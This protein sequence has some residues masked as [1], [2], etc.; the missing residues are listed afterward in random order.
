[1]NYIWK[2]IKKDPQYQLEEIIDWAAH[3]KYFQ[4]IVK[5]FDHIVTLREIFLICYIYNELKL[6]I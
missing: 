2:K 4:A 6:S 5:E 3:L 1:M